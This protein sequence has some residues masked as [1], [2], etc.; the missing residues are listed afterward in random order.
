M[1]K[2]LLWLTSLAVAQVALAQ[3][4]PL[5]NVQQNIE[6][7]IS[8]LPS[9]ATRLK[10]LANIDVL[11]LEKSESI[12]KL[13]AVEVKGG[14]LER[15]IQ[16]YWRKW[17]GK[18]VDAEEIQKFNGWLFAES[19]QLGYLSYSQTQIRREKEGDVLVVTITQPK[20]NAVQMVSGQPELTRKYG[21]MVLQRL[22]QDFQKGAPV[23]TLGLDQRLDSASYDLPIELDA[24]I[25]AVGPEQVDLIVNMNLAP[26]DPGQVLDGVVQLNNYGLRSY[27][28]PQVLASMTWRGHE[29]KASLNLLAQKSEGLTY[30]RAEYETALYG[31]MSRLR[32]WA[33]LSDS[34]NILGG[35]AAS[36]GDTA[37]LGVGLTRVMGGHRDFVFKQSADLLARQSKSELQS[38]GSGTGIHDQ[39]LRL[40]SAY[41]NEKLSTD[42]SRM[43]MLITAGNY[44]QL[45][46]I[47]TV[48]EGGYAKMEIAFRR[49]VIWDDERT[50]FSQFRFRSQVSSRRLDSYNQFALGGI[51]GVRAYTTVDGV[52]DNGAQVSAE[53]SKRLSNGMVMTGFYDGGFSKLLNPQSNFDPRDTQVLQ[54]LGVQLSG[55]YQRL[56][57]NLNV[58]KGIGGY[59][60]WNAYSI[61]SKPNNWRVSFA[62]SYML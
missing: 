23:D 38:G 1:N 13:A 14:A 56:S 40:R 35:Q 28:R 54:A 8:Q 22:Q 53:I 26:H 29:P 41:D 20:V 46:G 15:E 51:A 37:E 3:T 2:N 33:A 16:D 7:S 39:Q 57:Y 36:K 27:G 21:S 10:P 61:D 58:A 59:K 19:R 49:Q 6:Q 62:V 9:R 5:G 17:V 24:T 43:D 25:R 60:G 4:P 18:S 42:P 50:L 32:A 31:S 44:S 11:E 48:D 55:F 34:K 45:D 30:G 47:K 52:G 12:E